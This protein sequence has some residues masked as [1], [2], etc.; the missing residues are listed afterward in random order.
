HRRGDEGDGDVL[1]A[2]QPAGAGDEGGFL[3]GRVDLAHGRHHR[4]H[5]HEEVLD[6]V[7]HDHDPHGVV[8]VDDKAAG[9]GH[10][11]GEG[12]D[13]AGGAAAHGDEEI[14][15]ALALDVGALEQV[16]HDAGDD[17]AEGG[18]Q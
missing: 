12:D 17:D 8:D 4:P 7:G 18:G 16:G 6:H 1:E 2:P 14:R 5:P 9:H 3:Q 10:D 11:E 15:D 13:H